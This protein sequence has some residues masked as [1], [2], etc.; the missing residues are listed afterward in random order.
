[1][2]N[3]FL[4]TVALSL[5]CACG[6]EEPEVKRPSYDPLMPLVETATSLESLAVIAL[7]IEGSAADAAAIAYNGEL[8]QE[9]VDSRTRFNAAVYERL[10]GFKRG[11][12]VEL[13]TVF[14]ECAAK[15]C[16]EAASEAEL[17]A[18]KSMVQR[19]SAALYI[20]GQRACDPPKNV[21]DRYEEARGKVK[22]ANLCK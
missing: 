21:C 14:Y 7:C 16:K 8:P 19:C 20:D 4:L 22:N 15:V 12:F 2:K 6:G 9:F 13:R 18:V 10:A 11:H 17:D 5:L 3:F 1:M